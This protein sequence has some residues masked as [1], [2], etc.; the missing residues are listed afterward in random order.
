MSGYETN[1]SDTPLREGDNF[2]TQ[3]SGENIEHK[4][5]SCEHDVLKARSRN[6]RGA[7]NILDE[8][9]RDEE[10]QRRDQIYGQ[11]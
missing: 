3:S 7:A 9:L 4:V 1:L 10:G 8:V 11:K 5:V 6:A 2:Q